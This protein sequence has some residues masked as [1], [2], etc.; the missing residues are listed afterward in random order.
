MTPPE[1]QDRPRPQSLA[2]LFF[3]FTLLALQ[4]FGGVLA[5]VQHELVEKK[6]WMTREEFLEE[7]AVAQIMPGPNVVNLSL[8]IGARYFGLRGAMT[9]LAGMLFFPLIV[10]LLVTLVY[11]HF[12][13]HPGVTGALRGMGAVAAGLITA[14]GLRL[15]SALKSSPLGLPLCVL[16][17]VACFIGVALLRLPLTFVLPVLGGIACVIAYRRLKP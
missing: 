7:W 12:A 6:R 8:M 5:I 11:A 14:A 16:L 9:A 15:S 1:A 17:A 4:G 13:N 3:S 10:V 2:D